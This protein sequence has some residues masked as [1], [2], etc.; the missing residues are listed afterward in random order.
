MAEDFLSRFNELKVPSFN[1]AAESASPTRKP[2]KHL[3]IGSPEI[4]IST[5]QAL[6][7]L[8]YAEVGM[9]SPLLPTSNPGEVTSILI[10][11][12]VMQ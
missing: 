6:H 12:I 8:G 3:L 2:I 7:S 4:V 1:Q 11:Y 9:W 10:R 5:I